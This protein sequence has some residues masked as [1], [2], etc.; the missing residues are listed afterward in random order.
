MFS[1]KALTIAFIFNITLSAQ[2]S[3]IPGANDALRKAG[4]SPSEANSILLKKI[5]ILITLVILNL[6]ER[7]TKQG[8]TNR[9]NDFN[10]KFTNQINLENKS[11]INI[12]HLQIQMIP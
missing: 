12:F 2:I 7:D 5:L 1:I 10:K 3:K 9:N 11:S 4:I 8:S 6:I